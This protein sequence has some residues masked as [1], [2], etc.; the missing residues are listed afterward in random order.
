MNIQNGESDLFHILKELVE[1]QTMISAI[2]SQPQNKETASPSKLSVRPITVQNVLYYQI[3]EYS[4]QQVK[5]HNLLPSACATHLHQAFM[6]T[7]RQAQIFSEEADYHILLS[8]KGKLSIIKKKPTKHV[9]V[10]PHN[11]K[12]NY[13]LEDGE[14]VPFLIELGIMHP[15]GKVIDKKRDKFKQINRFLELANDV[16]SQLPSRPLWN[17]VDFGCGKSYL[18]F[19]LYHHLT[20]QQNLQVNLLGLDLKKEVIE[21]CQALA[22]QLGYHRLEFRHGDIRDHHSEDSVDMVISL[23]ACDTATDAALDKAIRWKADAI[24]CVPCCQHELLPQIQNASLQPLLKHG[25]LKERFS[26]LV[27]DAARGQLLEIHGYHTQILEFID[28]EHTAKNLMI[29]AIKNPHETDKAALI[30]K[31][32]EFTAALNISPCLES[33]QPLP[34]S[35]ETP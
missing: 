29:R 17:I 11:R 13:I 1:K 33:L 3:S 19:A 21:H 34:K 20:H 22:K 16:I 27:T 9:C 35:S 7:F 10:L 8:R 31:Y 28:L 6:H 4:Q 18:T 26:S 32:R 12:K 25:I 14:P 30:L 5:H 15:S 2:F 24:L 23:H